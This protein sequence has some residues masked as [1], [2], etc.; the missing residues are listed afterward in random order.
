MLFDDL[1][2]HDSQLEGVAFDAA[3]QTVSVHLLT[4]PEP[5]ASQRL[6]ITIV[7]NDVATFGLNADVASLADNQLAGNV[8]H[9]HI[10]DGGGTS[11]IYLVE[12]YISISSPSAPK[13][14]YR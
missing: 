12:G 10:A 3:K 9:W 11:H 14:V 1:Q 6:A 2:G 4:Y 8:N 5:N 7:F 13:L